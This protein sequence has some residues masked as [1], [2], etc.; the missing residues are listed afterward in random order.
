[1]D[2]VTEIRASVDDLRLV[3][4]PSLTKAEIEAQYRLIRFDEGPAPTQFQIA[5]PRDWGALPDGPDLPTAGNPITVLGRLQ[6]KDGRAAEITVFAARPGMELHPADFLDQ[7]LRDRSYAIREQ[8]GFETSFG[9]V[10]DVLAQKTEPGGTLFS[11]R[12][13]AIKDGEFV[14]VIQGRA[15]ATAPPAAFQDTFIIAFQTF[16]LLAPTKARFA[17]PFGWRQMAD[18]E[19]AL[20]PN[21][22]QPLPGRSFENA[23]GEVRLA[24]AL[25]AARGLGNA[26]P[27]LLIT[28]G[29]AEG[30]ASLAATALVQ[31]LG[32]ADAQLTPAPASEL[33]PGGSEGFTAR[34]WTTRLGEVPMSVTTLARAGTVLVSVSPAR[35]ADGAGWARTRRALDVMAETLGPVPEAR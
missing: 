6:P 26:R 34:L 7:W 23:P 21:A 12:L 3:V 32:G 8:R 18:G 22:F 24:A 9:R 14:Y 28:D 13:M 1:M 16:A 31:A 25:P 33:P 15:A 17:E 2:D 4:Q 5:A 20:L 35:E 29:L 19:R 10:A 27:A 11:S 30:E